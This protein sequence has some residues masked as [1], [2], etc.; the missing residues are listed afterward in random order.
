MFTAEHLDQ[1]DASRD[2][3]KYGFRYSPELKAFVPSTFAGSADSL[4]SKSGEDLSQESLEKSSLYSALSRAKRQDKTSTIGN[5]FP[6]TSGKRQPSGLRPDIPQRYSSL[7]SES[8]KKLRSST[9][10]QGVQ[11]DNA[12]QFTADKWA[13]DWLISDYDS[14]GN[15]A[16]K[17]STQSSKLLSI[18]KIFIT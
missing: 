7:H 14:Q 12:S 8:L 3:S 4:K 9:S 16:S 10:S 1:I 15:R 13:N 11:D 17:S 18:F 5:I 2:V 6:H